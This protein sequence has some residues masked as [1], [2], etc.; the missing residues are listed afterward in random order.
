[1][2]LT[3]SY[4]SCDTVL[5]DHFC[6]PCPSNRE[7]GRV[8]SAAFINS[9]Y[10]ATLITADP[11]LAASWQAGIDAG[12]IIIIPLTSGTFDPGEPKELKGF[13]D[14]KNSYG[15]RVQKLNFFD[16]NYVDNYQFYNAIT[17]AANLV[18]AYRTSN[19]IHIADVPASIF[20][21]DPVADDLQEEVLWD[22]SCTWESKTLPSVHDAA[23]LTEIFACN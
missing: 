12:E 17:D 6:D 2:S 19:V 20:A 22:V 7:F 18:V 23:N 10:L 9:A 8:R 5:P 14:R 1:M 21:K 15:P 13:G 4:N 11:T 16:P 3:N